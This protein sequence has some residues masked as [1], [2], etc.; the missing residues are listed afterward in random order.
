MD[1]LYR[2]LIGPLAWVSFTVFIAGSLYRLLHMGF[3]VRRKENFIF[4]VM[5]LKYSLRSIFHWMTPFATVNM[6]RHPVMTLAAFAFHICLF[7][8]PIFLVAH[9]V[10]W[11][12]GFNVRLWG[13]PGGLADIMTLVV[14][15]GCIFFLCRRLKLPEVRYL[16]T[17]SDY[18]LLI[19]VALPFLTGFVAYHQWADYRLCMT[20]HVLTGEIMLMAIPFTRLSHML[21]APFT[22]AYMGSE[23][24]GVRHAQDW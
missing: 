9:G 23:F 24:G 16:T 18:V 4:S 7:L 14:V 22:R 20:L 13:L 5:S 6:R 15:A 12:Y 11:E 2:F 3:L 8:T 10:L 17:P 1:A 19:I 21:F